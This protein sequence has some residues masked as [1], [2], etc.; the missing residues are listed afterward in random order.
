MLIL[1]HSSIP[2]IADT[3]GINVNTV[4]SIVYKM[5]SELDLHS[6]SSFV[7]VARLLKIV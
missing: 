1:Q 5:V 7:T 6:V 4:K 2:Q 3:L